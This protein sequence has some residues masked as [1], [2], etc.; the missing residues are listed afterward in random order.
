MKN[1]K[2][3]LI[4]GS[5]GFIGFHLAKKLL[6]DGF[7]VVGV[8]NLNNY[9]D[10][11]LKKERNKI[12][13]KYKNY[14]FNKIDIK[15]HKKLE[16]IFRKNKLDGIINL[17]A[18]AGVRYSLDNPK[19][20]IDNNI[21]GFFNVINLAVKFKVK[22]IIYASTSSIY[23]IQNKFPIK[24]NFDTNNPI[25][26]YAATKKANE[27]IA[28]SYSN[29]YNLKTIGLRFFTVYG[30]WG[31][32]DMALFKFTKNILKGKQIEVFNKGK[33]T[34]DFTY[35]DDIVDG[36]IKIIK[37]RKKIS[38]ASIYNIGSGKKVTL[39]EY[40]KLIE[41]YLNKK[42]KKRN[43]PLQK[44]D[45]IKTH[46]STKLLRNDFGYVSKTSVEKGVKKFIDWYLSYY[47]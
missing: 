39:M 3:Y 12:L 33:H 15:N 46:S 5:A 34:R 26:L 44:G 18:Q 47:R 10:Q 14:K 17:A 6:Q 35:V 43:L 13:G 28:A 9:Y 2:K 32:P 22:K 4:T 36:I 40:I 16:K 1:K 8:D 7:I 41:K 37:K 11:K 42:A 21:L 19:S 24:E 31:R 30:P 29:L 23:G 45:V 20:Y 27:V 25:Q 38:N